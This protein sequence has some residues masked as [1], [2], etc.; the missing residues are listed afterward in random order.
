MDGVDPR[1]SDADRQSTVD[2]LLRAFSDGCLTADE[3]DQRVASAY[4]A[5]TYR[6]LTALIRDL[7]GGLW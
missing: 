7:P 1:A 4:E 3:F 5:K 2:R 6:Q